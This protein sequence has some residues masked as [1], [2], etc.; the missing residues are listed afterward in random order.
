MPGA[1][2][3]AE[4]ARVAPAARCQDAAPGAAARIP[5]KQLPSANMLK[6][7]CT[8]YIMAVTIILPTSMGDSPTVQRYLLRTHALSITSAIMQHE[9]QGSFL[10]CMHP[11]S[12]SPQP[13]AARLQ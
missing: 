10:T 7:L 1:A 12:L 6:P 5:C 11:K 4:T 9:V 8:D 3:D 2:G 13:D